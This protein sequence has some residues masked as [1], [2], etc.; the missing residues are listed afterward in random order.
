MISQFVFSFFVTNLLLIL[1]SISQ[2]LTFTM[3]TRTF[4]IIFDESLLISMFSSTNQL[5]YSFIAESDNYFMLIWCY[6]FSPSFSYHLLFSLFH[7]SSL[8][9]SILLIRCL[10]FILMSSCVK[11][12]YYYRMIWELIIIKFEYIISSILHSF[13]KII[14]PTI[15]LY[16]ML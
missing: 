11:I 12:I 15:L 8:I 14:L 4:L 7:H 16:F 5:I 9:L 3:P 10:L 2:F 13:F 6:S 1:M